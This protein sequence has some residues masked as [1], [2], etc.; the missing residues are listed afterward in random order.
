MK[1]VTYQALSFFILLNT[2]WKVKEPIV[3]TLRNLSS[4]ILN[5]D[6]VYL[7]VICLRRKK[8]EMLIVENYDDRFYKS[9]QVSVTEK[10]KFWLSSLISDT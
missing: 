6:I 10:H 7:R 2:R 9:I 1:N 3:S 4:N 5:P 8:Q